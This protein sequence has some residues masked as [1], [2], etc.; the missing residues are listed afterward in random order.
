MAIRDERVAPVRLGQAHPPDI[1]VAD[2]A[3]AQ[4]RPCFG[5]RRECRA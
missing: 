3:I 2:F 5:K 1:A 4:L